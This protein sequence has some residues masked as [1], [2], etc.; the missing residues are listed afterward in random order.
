MEAAR[1]GKSLTAEFTKNAEEKVMKI[2]ARS[3]EFNEL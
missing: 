1:E 3:E 2:F